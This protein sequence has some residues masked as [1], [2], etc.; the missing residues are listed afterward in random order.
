MGADAV[1]PVQA[2]T[3]G[4]EMTVPERYGG[5]KMGNIVFVDIDDVLLTARAHALPSNAERIGRMS[6]GK[7]FGLDLLDALPTAFDP[8]AVA[9]LNRLATGVAAKIV[10]HSSWRAQFSAEEIGAHL[11]SQGVA[12]EHLHS[13]LCCPYAAMSTK[14]ENIAEWLS[15]VGDTGLW[16]CLDDEASVGKGLK[17]CG[18]TPISRYSDGERPRGLFVHVD[19]RTGFGPKEYA[20]ALSHFGIE[21]FLPLKGSVR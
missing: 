10:V 20:V 4:A 21:D 14:A 12:A 18:L 11:V 13:K 8:C 2:R 6:A 16:A 5:G 1:A 3:E 15:A 19:P 7:A 17:K 9:W